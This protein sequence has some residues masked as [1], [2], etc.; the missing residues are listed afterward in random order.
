MLL[1]DCVLI[2]VMRAC[3]SNRQPK[4]DFLPFSD[5]SG[6]AFMKAGP[7][8]DTGNASHQRS[9][10]IQTVRFAL[11]APL[12]Y[13]FYIKNESNDYMPFL[14]VC[15]CEPQAV[16]TKSAGLLSFLASFST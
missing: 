10:I 3:F 13:I 16:L 7:G 15:C 9:K 11:K 8:N 14:S 1:N 5:S 12:I 2:V 4:S 6:R